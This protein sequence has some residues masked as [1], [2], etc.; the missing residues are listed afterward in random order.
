MNKEEIKFEVT[1]LA[2]YWDNPPVAKIYIDNV[3]KWDKDLLPG[4]N[5]ITFNDTLDFTEHTLRIERSNKTDDQHQSDEKTQLLSLEKLVIDGVNIRDIVWTTSWY[6]PEYPKLW[7]LMQKKQGN[8]LEE[9]VLAGTT[10]GHNGNWYLNFT[11]PVYMHIIRW[12]NRELDA[13]I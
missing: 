12:M 13:V 3:C 4:L 6:E 9:T 8:V 11:S 1:L 5:T 10:W 7:A 2:E